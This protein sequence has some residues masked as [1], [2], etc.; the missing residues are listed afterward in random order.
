MKEN[1]VES[2]MI[3]QV[4][5]ELLFEVPVSEEKMMF[6][7]IIDKMENSTKLDIPLKVDCK[8]G[9]NWHDIH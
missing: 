9:D 3:L 8:I 6:E 1:K 7:L 2:R 4:H 5:D